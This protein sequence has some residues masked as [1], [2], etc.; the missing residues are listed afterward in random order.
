VS[1]IIRDVCITFT[2]L[3][4]IGLDG[5]NNLHVSLQRILQWWTH[6]VVIEEGVH[7]TPQ[8]LRWAP[9]KLVGVWLHHSPMLA[10]VHHRSNSAAPEFLQMVAHNFCCALPSWA[11]EEPSPIILL[12]YFFFAGTRSSSSNQSSSP[13]EKVL[14]FLPKGAN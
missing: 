2:H 10:L 7:M 4:C 8:S 11:M 1:K 14:T 3:V 12:L 13:Q 5:C 6:F 9:Q